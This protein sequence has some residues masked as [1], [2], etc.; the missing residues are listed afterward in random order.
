MVFQ[1]KS[2]RFALWL[3]LGAVASMPTSAQF[4]SGSIVGTTSDETGAV[5]TKAK[6]TLRNLG[7]SEERQTATDDRGDYTFPSLL[8]GAYSVTAEAPGFKTQVLSNINVEVN[9]T[10]RIDMKLSVG[11]LAQRVEATASLQLLKTDNSE[12]GSV[13]GNKQIVELPL[14]GRDYLQ[15]ARLIQGRFLPVPARPLG[16]KE[17]RAASMWL[18]PEIP[19]SHS[20]WMALIQTM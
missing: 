17:F 15:L 4:Q 12:I 3:V 9:Q 13:I 10:A 18:V 7:T 6:V 2:S 11:D 19:L 20:Y 16:R 5:I 14:N 8:S 1:L